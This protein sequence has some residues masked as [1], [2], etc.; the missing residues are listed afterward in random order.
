MKWNFRDYFLFHLALWGIFIMNQSVYSDTS[1]FAIVDDPAL[2]GIMAKVRSEFLLIHPYLSRLDSTILIPGE[3]G[4][5]R[6]GSY[7]PE[8]IAYPAS[9]VKLAYLA[10]AMYWCRING[11]P[12]NHLDN[13]IRPMIERSDNPATG[14]VID[15]ITL[16]PNYQT[17][18]RD[19]QFD[20]W[21]R[22]RQFTEIY[23]KS[24]GL[25][26]NQTIMHKTYPSNSGESPNGAEKL[27]LDLRN[28]NR[29]QPKCS[30]SLMLEIVK[31]AI[32]PGANEYMRSLLKHDRWSGNSEFGFGLPPGSIYENKYGQA[33]DTLEDIA[34]IA[35][36][37]GREFILAAFSNG[38]VEPEKSNPS[39]YNVSLLGG[40]CEALIEAFGLDQGCPPK[41]K[42]DNND[43]NVTISGDWSAGTDPK[44]DYDMFGQN[45]LFTTADNAGTKSVTWN[46]KVPEAG[47]YEVCVWHPQKKAGGIVDFTI[48]HAAG[49]T[50]VDVNQ[51]VCGGRWRRLGDYEFKAGEGSVILTNLGGSTPHQVILADAVKI[52]RWHGAAKP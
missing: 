28:G 48:H 52:T 17:S 11:F 21:N 45:Y 26:E 5:W 35:L 32:E 16:A 49:S 13:A 23:L 9:S 10:S 36:P 46:L 33:Y 25:L 30:A 37:N 14:R 12:Y 4:T 29:M 31:G 24:R 15:A 3:N 47:L 1:A 44:T 38:Y 22:K 34:Y 51:Q 8:V 39:P 7:N 27:A 19:R 43:P 41:I 2:S 50:K 6:R 42:I 18:V 20:L 40:Y